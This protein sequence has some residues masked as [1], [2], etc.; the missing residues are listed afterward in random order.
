MYTF[1]SSGGH[2]E[3]KVN[4]WLEIGRICKFD[5]FVP[6]LLVEHYKFS[7][8]LEIIIRKIFSPFLLLL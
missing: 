7:L 4:K 5:W 1:F 2:S 8:A 3:G 6:I